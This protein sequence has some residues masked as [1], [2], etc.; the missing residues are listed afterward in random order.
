MLALCKGISAL[1]LFREAAVDNKEPSEH[2]RKS[3]RSHN[4][5]YLPLGLCQPDLVSTSPIGKTCL[6]L[7]SPF[8]FNENVKEE[9]GQKDLANSSFYEQ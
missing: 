3:S 5:P 1:P 4:D 8:L 7:F 6:L 2:N 9:K